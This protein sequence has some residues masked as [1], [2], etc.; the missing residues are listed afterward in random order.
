MINFLNT[1]DSSNDNYLLQLRYGGKARDNNSTFFVNCEDNAAGRLN[2]YADGDVK[3]MIIH[4]VQYQMRE[5][6][7]ILLMQTLSGMT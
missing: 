1:D 4:M 5:L 7:K 2:I 6:N 3:I